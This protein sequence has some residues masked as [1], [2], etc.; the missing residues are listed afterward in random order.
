MTVLVEIAVIADNLL[1]VGQVDY[2]GE[3]FVSVLG[4]TVLGSAAEFAGLSPGATIAVYGGLDSDTGGYV[5]T[6]V[7]ALA[8]AGVDAGAQDFLRGTVDSV[9]A[10]LGVAVVSGVVVDYTSTLANGAAPEVGQELAV[11]GRNYR[12]LGVL[13]AE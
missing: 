12:G 4:Q 13:V 11:S 2:V 10:S 8:P 1:T 7:V 5:D 6:S 3:G 9:D